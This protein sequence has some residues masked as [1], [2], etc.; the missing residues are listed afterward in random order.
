MPRLCAPFA[1][2]TLRL[3]PEDF[4]RMASRKILHRFHLPKLPVGLM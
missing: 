3:S 4:V 2:Q 1:V